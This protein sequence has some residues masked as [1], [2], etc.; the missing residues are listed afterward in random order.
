VVSH[1]YS[2]LKTRREE[3][4]RLGGG[5]LK[6]ENKTTTERGRREKRGQ[7]THFFREFSDRKGDCLLLKV[8]TREGDGGGGGK[9]PV[10]VNYENG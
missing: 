1:L 8:E 6:R 3:E 5:H 9:G 4:E 7:Q 2:F 10:G